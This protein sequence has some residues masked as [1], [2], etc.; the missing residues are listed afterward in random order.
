MMIN[1]GQMKAGRHS[2][3]AAR[4]T[5]SGEQLSPTNLFGARRAITGRIT[6]LGLV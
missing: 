5:G 3:A 6:G 2:S 1:A 4:L